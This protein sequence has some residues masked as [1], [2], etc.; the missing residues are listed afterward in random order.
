MINEK[1]QKN[2]HLISNEASEFSHFRIDASELGQVIIA[3]AKSESYSDPWWEAHVGG[4]GRKRSVLRRGT[5]TDGL[6]VEVK[7]H[8]QDEY[9]KI[10]HYIGVY[11]YDGKIVFK[12]GDRIW[13]QHKDS[14]IKKNELKYFYING[15]WNVY[16]GT[17]K[18]T[19]RIWK[20]KAEDLEGE[21][22]L[23]CRRFPSDLAVKISN[24]DCNF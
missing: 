14:S 3:L 5:I 8:S 7:E 11:V 1:N 13:M 10:N 24:F 23:S 17:P 21:S 9:Q 18:G 19:Y 2:Y 16:H 6:D 20:F 4:W 15:N 12:A 22:I